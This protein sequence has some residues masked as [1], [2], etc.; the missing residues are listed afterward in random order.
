[1]GKQVMNAD[2]HAK[3]LRKWPLVK[4]ATATQRA[5]NIPN[6]PQ[7]AADSYALKDKK[8]E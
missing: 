3:P 2:F 4:N 1:M 7:Y 6:S 5:I 8:K